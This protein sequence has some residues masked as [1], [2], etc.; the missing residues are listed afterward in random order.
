MKKLLSLLPLLGLIGSVKASC[1][2]NTIS[3][4]GVITDEFADQ[5]NWCFDRDCFGDLKFR[6]GID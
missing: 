6:G 2:L 4:K 3:R 5:F 1:T